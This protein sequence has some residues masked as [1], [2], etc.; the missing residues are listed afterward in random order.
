MPWSSPARDVGHPPLTCRYVSTKPVWPPERPSLRPGRPPS[1]RGSTND[2][3]R[4]P[5]CLLADG[6]Q[7]GG[8]LSVWN[9]FH[10]C[11]RRRHD[12]RWRPQ[13][14]QRYSP[15]MEFGPMT[16]IAICLPSSAARRACR[17]YQPRLHHDLSQYRPP[18]TTPP[19]SLLRLLG[20]AA[21]EG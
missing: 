5:G 21:D 20:A 4:H 14:R 7:A 6:W 10:H 9:T 15:P 16:S 12:P 3:H 19:L 18:L 13:Q 2:H 11:G 17:R 8:C 1:D